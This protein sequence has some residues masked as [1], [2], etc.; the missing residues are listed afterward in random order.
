MQRQFPIVLVGNA[1][2]LMVAAIR[3]A[4]DCA[5]IAIVN[6][7]KNWGG[8]FSTFIANS[9]PFDP[10]MVL[11]EFT[12]FNS[13]SREADPATYDPAIRNDAGRFCAKVQTFVEGYQRTHEIPT[14]KMYIDGCVLD[15][16][17]IA[18][19]L[20]SL[21]ELSFAEQCTQELR[22]LADPGALHASHKLGS[23][24]FN[25][26][27]YESASLAN[28][29]ETFHARLIEPFCRKLLNI[30]TRDMLALYHRVAWL[31]LFYPETLL[32]HF[33][34]NPQALPPTAFSYPTGERIGDLAT[35]LKTEIEG[36][37]RITIIQDSLASLSLAAQGRI[38]LTLENGDVISSKKVAWANTL[39]ELLCAIGLEQRA[40]TYQK[41]S[42]AL[43]FLRLPATMLR[44]D[45]SVLSVVDS[46]FAI[47][48]ITNQSRCT[49]QDAGT[50]DIVVELNPDYA[51]SLDMDHGT[52]GIAPQI[53]RELLE[54]GIITGAGE[55][56]WLAVKQ[57][58]NALML[59]TRGN[60]TGFMSERA[61]VLEAVPG[62]SLL[63]PAS[64]FFSSSCNDQ[65]VQGLQFGMLQERLP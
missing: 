3:L 61:A 31:P 25:E 26:F 28:H 33:H 59:P 20:L 51:A 50:V 44:L 35:K 39:K 40:A 7:T 53:A 34:G 5:E 16:I 19:S 37:A 48:R 4:R 55:I 57:M 62:V 32:S 47:Y 49:G 1:L 38:A 10:G 29:G 27:D 41:C 8:H 52:S 21:R 63:G 23:V 30:P 9:V 22:H 64:G 46:R 18:N 43:A 56:E 12:S 42:I 15:D 60:R 58:P 6:P 17:L 14:P 24:A 36:N 11:Y 45:F 2:S 13:E 54:L 65:I